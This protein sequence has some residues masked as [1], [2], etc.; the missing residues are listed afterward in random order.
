MER[1]AAAGARVLRT[2]EAGTIACDWRSGAW[3]CSSLTP[4]DFDLGGATA[5]Y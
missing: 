4:V 5:Q 3:R 2:D 1:W